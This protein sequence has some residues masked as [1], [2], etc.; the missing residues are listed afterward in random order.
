MPYLQTIIDYFED[1]GLVIPDD[2]SAETLYEELEA[3]WNPNNRFPIWKILGSDLPNFIIW[4]QEQIDDEQEDI[5]ETITFTPERAERD[6][7]KEERIIDKEIKLFTARE[8]LID[9]EEARIE[10]SRGGII[11]SIKSF[12]R[13]IFGG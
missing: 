7:A 9:V 1:Q 8:E 6:E 10:P 5:T 12:I 3:E 11:A 2:N 13:N 4:L